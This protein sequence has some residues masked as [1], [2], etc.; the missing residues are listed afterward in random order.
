[1]RID[2][3][4]RRVRLAREVGTDKLP[5]PSVLKREHNVPPVDELLG[6]LPVSQREVLTML[7]VDGLSV[8]EIARATS[9]TVGAVKQKA[10]RAYER[11]RDILQPAANV[12]KRRK[13]SAR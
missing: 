11:L 9:S 1:V 7:K 8:E 6:M 13:G 4:R 12:G 5:E 2:A 3:F 10:H